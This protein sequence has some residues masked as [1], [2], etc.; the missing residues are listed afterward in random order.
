MPPL[1]LV[2]LAELLWQMFYSVMVAVGGVLL[3]LSG[4]FYT[5]GDKVGDG[6]CSML[7]HGVEAIATRKERSLQRQIDR[8]LVEVAPETVTGASISP[9][10]MTGEQSNRGIS[11]AK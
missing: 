6:V 3:Y 8:A 9:T 5:F 10:R 2:P 7:R 11:V 1:A 4:P